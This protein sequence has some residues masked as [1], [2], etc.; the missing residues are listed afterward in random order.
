MIGTVANAYNGIKI[1]GNVVGDTFFYGQGAG[2]DATASAVMADIIDACKGNSEDTLKDYPGFKVFDGADGLAEKG[3]V[4]CR[5][6]LNVMVQDSPSSLAAITGVLGECGVS[7]A[8]IAQKER[9]ENYVP[10]VIMTH[11]VPVSDV[12]KAIAKIAELSVVNEMPYSFRIED[13]D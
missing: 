13:I 7:I 9:S 3:S 11:E 10:V 4:A 12:E 5:F 6:Y 2:K 8:S 1:S